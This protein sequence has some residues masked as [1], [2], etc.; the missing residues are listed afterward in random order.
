MS[1]AVKMVIHL[2]SKL[3]VEG[4]ILGES[5]IFRGNFYSYRPIAMWRIRTVNL[6]LVGLTHNPW[7]RGGSF[8]KTGGGILTIY[9]SLYDIKYDK[10]F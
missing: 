6:E 3:L 1:E 2:D 9:P 4:S 10:D 5:K 8:A 7:A